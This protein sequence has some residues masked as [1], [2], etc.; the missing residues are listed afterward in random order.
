MPMMAGRRA[1]SARVGQRWWEASRR[2]AGPVRGVLR[3]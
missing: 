3:R 2:S 1:P